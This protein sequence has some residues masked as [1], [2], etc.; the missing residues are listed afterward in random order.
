MT[1]YG[2]LTGHFGRRCF[3]LVDIG[4][5]KLDRCGYRWT[6]KPCPECDAPNDIAARYCCECKAEIVDPNDR[7]RAEF[8]AMKKDPTIPQ[9]DEVVSAVYHDG[10]SSKGRRTIRAEWT[11]PYRKFTTWHDPEPKFPKAER[12]FEMFWNATNGATEDPATI[13]YIKNAETGFYRILGF[14]RAADHAPE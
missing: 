6:S 11:T 12:D 5:G 3:G 9:T 14:N 4:G 1:E 10:L 8:K 2:P 13:S 7:L